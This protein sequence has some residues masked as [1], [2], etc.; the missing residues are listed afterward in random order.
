MSNLVPWFEISKECYVDMTQVAMMEEIDYMTI[1]ITLKNGI[2]KTI[3]T[4]KFASSTIKRFNEAMKKLYEINLSAPYEP[5]EYCEADFAK[6][7]ENL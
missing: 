5:E 2:Q 1:L 3:R 7:E 4:Q 6:G